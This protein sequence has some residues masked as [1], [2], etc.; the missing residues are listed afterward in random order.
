MRRR[1][2]KPS[3]SVMRLKKREHRLLEIAPQEYFA[4]SLQIQLNGLA[5]ARLCLRMALSF[6]NRPPT[7]GY[8]GATS[9]RFAITLVWELGA[10]LSAYTM[11]MKKPYCE[12][13]GMGR[14]GSQSL[15]ALSGFVTYLD[16][17]IVVYGLFFLK[18]SAIR[19]NNCM[20]LMAIFPPF[21]CCSPLLILIFIVLLIFSIP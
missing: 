13:N 6:M 2:G 3:A 1:S 9:Q 7:H 12:K 14:F 17:A 11:P 4:L 16:I 10:R 21:L 15:L 5:S 8:N 18:V 20:V 19:E